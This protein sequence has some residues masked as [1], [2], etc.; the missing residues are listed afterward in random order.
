MNTS[1]E[2]W[3]AGETYEHFMGR[4]SWEMASRFLKWIPHEAHQ[5]W[6]DI[7][8]GTGSLTRRIISDCNPLMTIGLDRSLDF[9][10]YAAQ[11]AVS[12][13]FMVSDAMQVA[14]GDQAVDRVVSGLVMN[15][16]PHP[17]QAIREMHRVVKPGGIAAAYVWDYAGQM[18]FLRYFWDAAV[19]LD[20]GAIVYHEGHRFPICQP[21]P[22]SCL[23]QVGGF[24]D[25]T[26]DSLD[27]LTSF[28]S[29]EDY[30]HPFTRGKFPA[31][32]YLN[33]LTEAGRN[34]LR[35]HLR[36][37]L[38]TRDDGSITLTARAIAV[39]G[40]KTVPV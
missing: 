19:E 20:S 31:P 8:C 39:R 11:H 24:V 23:W 17:E 25:V 18:E 12:A 14:V 28:K 27:I 29:F 3:A 1:S 5:R 7:G 26:V 13:R 21:E 34:A 36:T 4:W 9:V 40:V 35:E 32:A 2:R 30:W 38:P 6:L 37:T 16:I 33:S 15:F 22:L 10:R